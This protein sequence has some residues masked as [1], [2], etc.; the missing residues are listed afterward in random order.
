MTRLHVSFRGVMLFGLVAVAVHVVD[1]TLAQ[2]Q[3]GTSP[4]DH[5]V[6]AL[7]PLCL[8]AL[9]GAGVW[10]GGP[11]RRSAIALAAGFFGIVAGV[12]G[13]YYT[14]H[15]GP[16]GDDFTGLLSLAAGLTLVGTALATLWKERRKDGGR[17]RRYL[18]RSLILVLGGLTLFYVGFPVTVAY[19]ASHV[20]RLPASHVDLGPSARDV[21]L[22][23]SMIEYL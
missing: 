10:R 5:L 1:D 16:S 6:S 8:L 11:G 3:P 23:P 14:M 17:A 13:V 19:V 4:G 15:G 22:D 2:P 21:V 9:A 20:G 18:R 12:E 7:V